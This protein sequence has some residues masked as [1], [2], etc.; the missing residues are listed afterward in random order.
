MNWIVNG[1]CTINNITHPV[2]SNHNPPPGQLYIPA[3]T[4]QSPYRTRCWHIWLYRGTGSPVQTHQH[5][6][7][8]II[9]IINHG[10]EQVNLLLHNMTIFVIVDH[11]SGSMTWLHTSWTATVNI[12]PT[13]TAASKT[14]CTIYRTPSL[15][16]LTRNSAVIATFVNR[17]HWNSYL[18][19]YTLKPIS[20][21]TV[22]P[23]LLIILKAQSNLDSE[24][25]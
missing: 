21:L 4:C 12:L 10:I 6:I 3:D 25:T 24:M 14:R 11:Q 15:V 1:E 8:Y 9:I 22:H 23:W 19:I 16:A 7:L 17:T 13:C 5:H 20:S 18:A 2:S